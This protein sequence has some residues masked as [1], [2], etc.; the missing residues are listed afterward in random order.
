VPASSWHYSSSGHLESHRRQCVTEAKATRDTFHTRKVPELQRTFSSSQDA[1]HG[2]LHIIEIEFYK[3]YLI[4][5][6]TFRTSYQVTSSI[7]VIFLPP[8]TI[9]TIHRVP[10]SRTN[11]RQHVIP[12]NPIQRHVP[13]HFHRATR[14]LPCNRIL[15]KR[16]KP[17]HKLVLSNWPSRIHQ[18][19][20]Q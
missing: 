13:E 20:L 17:I 11:I 14:L 8:V 9:A 6:Y 4:H 5:T 10:T 19:L 7:T 3:S 1:P 12:W 15:P 16:L 2:P 18:N